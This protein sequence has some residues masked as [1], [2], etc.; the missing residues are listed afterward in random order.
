MP[1][2]GGKPEGTQL[3]AAW[4]DRRNDTNNSLIEYYGRWGSIATNGN[5][6]FGAEFKIST[7][8]FP[9]VFA[10]T[11]SVNTNQGHYD[12]VYPPENVNLHWWYP[13]WP[14]PPPP[15]E[16]DENTTVNAYASHVGEYNGAWADDFAV[17]LAWTDYRLPSAGTLYPRNQSDVR[18]VRIRWPQ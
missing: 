3:L 5:V 9:P 16:Q 11:L 4:Y 17:Y 12:P 7:T 18:L 8:N 15:D 2:L 1:V 13:E 6:A 14:A 10:G